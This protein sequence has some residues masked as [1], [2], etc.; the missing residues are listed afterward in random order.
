ME[1]RRFVLKDDID[2]ELWSGIRAIDDST[3]GFE[4]VLSEGD[5]RLYRIT[6]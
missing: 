1:R 2:N 3:P 6:A 4:T 5:M